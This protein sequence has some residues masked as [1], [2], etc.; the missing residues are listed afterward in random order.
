M[1]V[2]DDA[3]GERERGIE[4]SIRGRL[5]ARPDVELVPARGLPRGEIKP[6]VVY[7]LFEDGAPG[8]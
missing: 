1:A 6:R 5:I 4:G 7:V 3:V 8:A 2:N